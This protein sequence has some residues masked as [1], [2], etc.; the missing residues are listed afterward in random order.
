MKRKRNKRN[1]FLFYQ[2]K[3]K[4]TNNIETDNTKRIEMSERCMWIEF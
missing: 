3:T 1:F 2:T 4:I